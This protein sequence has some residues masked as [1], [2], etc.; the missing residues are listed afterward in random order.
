MSEFLFVKKNFRHSYEHAI[1]SANPNSKIGS[2][3]SPENGRSVGFKEF[4]TLVKNAAHALDE[5]GPNKKLIVTIAGNSLQHMA[6]I[7]AALLTGRSVCLINP[8]E[9]VER[10]QQKISSLNEDCLVVTDQQDSQWRQSLNAQPMRLDSAPTNGNVRWVDFPAD[11]PFILIFTSGSTGYSK[12]VEQSEI[13]VLT[14]VDALIERH[15]LHAGACI[16]TPLPISHVNALEFSFFSS[17]LAGSSLVLLGQIAP[18]YF[19]EVIAREHCTILSIVPPILRSLVNQAAI[20]QKH[21]LSHLQYFATAAAPLSTDLL[22]QALDTFHVPVIQGYGLSEAIN[23]SCLMPTD[24]NEEAYRQVMLQEPWP[25]IGTPLRGSV[26]EVLGEDGE[27]LKEGERGQIAIGGP[28]VMR[29]YRGDTNRLW[30]KHGYLNTGDLGYY[31]IGQDGRKYFYI[32]GRLKEIAKRNGVT[33]ALREID[34]IMANFDAS[35]DCIA[36]AFANDVAGE[37]VAI[38]VRTERPSDKEFESK[39]RTYVENSLPPHIR[40]RVIY[41]TKRSLRTASGKPQR[42]KFNSLFEPFK[43]L[44]IGGPIRFFTDSLFDDL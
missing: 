13:G 39:L 30:F 27:I 22:R 33:I 32:S 19:A 15:R 31:R 6:Y 38:L 20:F 18:S 12:I 28:T 44:A 37:E 1:H 41:F 29:G 40:P 3:L 16:G 11:R 9:G 36:V 25:S 21:D 2:Y 42:H 10:I 14:N 17:L 34:D 7:V 23:F 8:Q 35:C 5:D 4:D 24:L 43:K 26:V